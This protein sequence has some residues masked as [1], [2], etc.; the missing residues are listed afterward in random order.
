MIYKVWSF[1]RG[2]AALPSNCCDFLASNLLFLSCGFNWSRPLRSTGKRAV[3]KVSTVSKFLKGFSFSAE[4]VG[5]I[6][7]EQIFLFAWFSIKKY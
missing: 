1:R 3:Q 5:A 6:F 4:N 2:V 7:S